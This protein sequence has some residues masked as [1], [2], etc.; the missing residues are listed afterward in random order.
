MLRSL[1]SLMLIGALAGCGGVSVT[2]NPDPVAVTG[3][4]TLAGK[5]VTDIAVN[6]QPIE[7]GLPAVVTVKDGKFEAQITP[8]KYTYFVSKASTPTGER[9]L[10]KVPTPLHQGAMDRVVEVTGPGPVELAMN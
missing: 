8:G 3:N 7:G 1:L 5:P 10:S 4:V 6:F 9:S 2:P